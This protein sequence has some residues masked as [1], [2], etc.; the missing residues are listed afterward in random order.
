M[1]DL[2][3]SIDAQEDIRSIRMYSKL[4]WGLSQSENYINGLQNHLVAL[5][6]TPF[7][8]RARPD[9]YDGAYSLPYKSHFIY[10]SV[11]PDVIIITRVLHKSMVPKLHLG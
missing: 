10:Y 6:Q 1:K 4:H 2:H 3:I 5:S 7:I 9:I 8:G 11:L